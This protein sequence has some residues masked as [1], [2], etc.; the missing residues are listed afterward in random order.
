[1]NYLVALKNCSGHF[2]MVSKS[3]SCLKLFYCGGADVI[4]GVPYF[5]RLK[6]AIILS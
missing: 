4:Y 6:C 1:M 2:L 3:F 5:M